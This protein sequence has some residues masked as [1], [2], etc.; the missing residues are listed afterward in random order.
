METYETLGTVESEG[1]LRVEGVPFPP[2]TRVEVTISLQKRSPSEVV[3]A[4]HKLFA[5]LDQSRNVVPVGPLDRE[6]LYDRDDV[7]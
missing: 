3:G 6:G 5:A 7:H 1:Q 2:G 4:Y